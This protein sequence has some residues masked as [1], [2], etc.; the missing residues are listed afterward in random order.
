M[1]PMHPTTVEP[2]NATVTFPS[3]NPLQQGV[4]QHHRLVFVEAARCAR[5]TGTGTQIHFGKWGTFQ[6][7]VGT[8]VVHLPMEHA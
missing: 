6:P 5:G 2:H 4:P 1:Q 7:E 8:K 3:S